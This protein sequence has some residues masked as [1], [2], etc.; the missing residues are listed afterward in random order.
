MIILF[1]NMFGSA[2]SYPLEKVSPV[3]VEPWKDLLFRA[4][5]SA[6][7]CTVTSQLL[8][9]GESHCGLRGESQDPAFPSQN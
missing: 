9:G 3:R 5:S 1:A 2:V 7:G 6:L 4:G 8:V